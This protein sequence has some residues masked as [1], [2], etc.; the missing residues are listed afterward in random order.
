VRV[1]GRVTRVEDPGQLLVSL[2][3]MASG[4]R[5]GPAGELDLRQQRRQAPGQQDTFGPD[6]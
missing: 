2:V 6:G 1:I 3:E 4:E 5:R